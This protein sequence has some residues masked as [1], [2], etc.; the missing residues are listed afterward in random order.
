MMTKTKVLDKD[1]IKSKNITMI[2]DT[3]WKQCCTFK[4]IIVITK[5]DLI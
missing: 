1:F 3:T 2:N 4:M 5:A